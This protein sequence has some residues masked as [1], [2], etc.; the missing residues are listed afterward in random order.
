MPGQDKYLTET[1]YDQETGVP[2]WQTTTFN[3]KRHAPPDGTPSYVVFDEQGRPKQLTWHAFDIEHRT[4]GPSTI[5]LDPETNVHR[6]ESYYV[7][8]QPRDPTVGPYRVCRYEDGEI[9]K[10]EFNTPSGR[11]PLTGLTTL[12]N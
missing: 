9:W 4:N 6:V 7:Q 11:A 2:I 3:G 1:A 12:E 10:E 5:L 8:G